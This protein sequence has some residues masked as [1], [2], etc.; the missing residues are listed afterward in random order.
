MMAIKTGWE[1]R[2]F[3]DF[4]AGDVYRSRIGRTITDTDNTQLTLHP[5]A[6]MMNHH[7]TTMFFHDLETLYEATR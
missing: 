5:L 1:G 6:T 3:E 4:A 7:S 2:Y